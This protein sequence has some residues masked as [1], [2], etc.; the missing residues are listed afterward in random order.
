MA[1]HADQMLPLLAGATSAERRLFSAFKY[2]DNRVVLHSDRSLMPKRKSVWA[3]WNYLSEEVVD[4][5]ARVSVTYWM[6]RLQR[7]TGD[8][9]YFVS[10][11]PLTEPKDVIFE[12]TYA[13]PV[14]TRDAMQAQEKLAAHPGCGSRVVLRRLERLRIS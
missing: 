1:V 13:H 8:T 7:L 11:N 6:N 9:D 3:S 10:L 14:F 12:T 2:Q 4:G 5:K